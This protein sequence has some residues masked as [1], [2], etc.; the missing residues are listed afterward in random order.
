MN[1][2]CSPGAPVI[3]VCPSSRSQSGLAQTRALR[4]KPDSPPDWQG[5]SLAP[6]RVGRGEEERRVGKTEVTEC[7]MNSWLIT[8]LLLGTS[9]SAAQAQLQLL[10]VPEPKQVF[11]GDAR[12]ITLTWHNAGQMTF[13]QELSARLYQASSATT[14]PLG[15]TPW[16]YLEILPGQTVIESATLNFPAV[17]AETRFVI[18]WL[19]GANRVVGTSEVRVYPTNL[20][21]ELKALAGEEPLGVLD[22]QNQLKP[23]LKAAAVEFSDLEDGRVEDYRGKLAIAGPFQNKTQMRN[24]LVTQLQALAKRGVGVVWLLPPQEQKDRRGERLRPSFYTVPE[25]KGVVV[26]AQASLTASLSESPPA[27]LNLTQ[28]ARLALHP[29]APRL[30]DPTP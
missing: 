7:K 15:T 13:G 3:P 2:S 18:Q 6:R 17:H 27:Q 14:V 22:P 28:L 23:L 29:E 8:L 5:F 11:G 24:G 1:P 9:P 19:A 4:T 12:T 21:T 16:R 10:P 30:P 25:G 26:V 20:L